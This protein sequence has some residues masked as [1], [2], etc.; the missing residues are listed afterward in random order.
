MLGALTERSSMEQRLL[1]KKNTSFMMVISSR[2]AHISW[3]FKLLPR[4]RPLTQCER[5][6]HHPRHRRA[7]RRRTPNGSGISCS[8]PTGTLMMCLEE[9]GK[10]I[11]NPSFV[12]RLKGMTGAEYDPQCSLC[13]QFFVARVV[14]PLM[15]GRKRLRPRSSLRLQNRVGR[16]VRRGFLMAAGREGYTR[17]WLCPGLLSIKIKWHGSLP[18]CCR[19]SVP[20]WQMP[21]GA[22][23]SSKKSSRSRPPG[24]WPGNRTPSN[25]RKMRRRS[26][27]SCSIPDRVDCR[28]RK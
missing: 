8:E 19:P 13:G 9:T 26:Q 1:Q 6:L 4:K 15:C 11:W 17:N 23:E 21:Y 10:A 7:Q 3:F 27:P 20:G 2:S 22:G 24:S 28:M 16:K 25:M 18:V 5:L 14:R 12:E